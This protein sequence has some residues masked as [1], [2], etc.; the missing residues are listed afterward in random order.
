[1]SLLSVKEKEKSEKD[2]ENV[3]KKYEQNG[4]SRSV[5]NLYFL[6][7]LRFSF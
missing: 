5:K 1:M 4:E 3:T 2:D 7:V 6:F